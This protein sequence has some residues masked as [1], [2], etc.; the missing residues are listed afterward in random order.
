MIKNANARST[1][2]ML[3][4]DKLR[5]SEFLVKSSVAYS[6]PM[7]LAKLVKT[8]PHLKDCPIHTWRASSG[9]ELIHKEPDTKEQKRIYKNWL[10]MSPDQKA[11]SDTKAKE[12][13]GKTNEEHHRE[14]MEKHWSKS[15]VIKEEGGGFTLYTGDGTRVLGKHPTREKAMAQERAIQISKHLRGK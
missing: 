1:K 8:Y 13:F 7:E 9:V 2:D 12:L 4:T 10:A 6:R 5:L 14:I 3:Y 11:V 15:A